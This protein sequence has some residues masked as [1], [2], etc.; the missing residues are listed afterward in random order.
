MIDE[1]PEYPIKH[2]KYACPSHEKK[3]E[4]FEKIKKELVKKYEVND[5]DGIK[6]F[7]NKT[8]WVLIR[9][10]N[11]EPLIRMTVEASVQKNLDGLFTE[12]EGLIKKFINNEKISE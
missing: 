10:S 11:T 7:I 9:P 12:F 3:F 6:F 1:L 5:C 8:D 2:S 4:A